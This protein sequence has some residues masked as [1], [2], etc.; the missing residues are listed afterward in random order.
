MVI[1][2]ELLMLVLQLDT[3]M[4]KNLDLMMDERLEKLKD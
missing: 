1:V 2:S 4:G 3:L